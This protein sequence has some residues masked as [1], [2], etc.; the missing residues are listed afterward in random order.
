MDFSVDR[1]NF[2]LQAFINTR[3]KR[4]GI[5]L[6]L[7]GPNA[8]PHY[9]LLEREKAVIESELGTQFEWAAN[10][11]KV[12]RYVYLH[13]RTMNPLAREQWP[14]QHTWLWTKL[15][16]FK[17]VFA[18]RVRKLDASNYKAEESTEQSLTEIPPTD[19]EN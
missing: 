4:I 9:Y 14:Q 12:M 15:E 18:L 1:S 16:A 2:S 7:F 8:K 17:K 5:A 11:G 3:D 6:A 10:P 19:I 13:E